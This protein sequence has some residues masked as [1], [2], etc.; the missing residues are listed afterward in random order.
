MRVRF[1]ARPLRR[2][3][4]QRPMDSVLDGGAVLG[5]MGRI[6]RTSARQWRLCHELHSC[7]SVALGGMQDERMAQPNVARL[8]RGRDFG[9]KFGLPSEGTRRTE[10]LNW[11]ASAKYQSRSWEVA[12]Q[13]K[14]GWSI[15]RSNVAE[16]K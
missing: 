11:A 2:S 4:S 15:I 5:G 7:T 14:P 6:Y 16:E 13:T 12:A 1:S 3:G 9:Q 10:E 8:A